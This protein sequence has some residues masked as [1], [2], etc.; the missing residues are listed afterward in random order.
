MLFQ[1]NI[2]RLTL[3]MMKIVQVECFD[4]TCWYFWGGLVCGTYSEDL[5]GFLDDG[6]GQIWWICFGAMAMA[7]R[8]GYVLYVW[9]CFST[10]GVGM[11]FRGVLCW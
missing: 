2:T 10:A 11:R 4:A 6:R 9:L 3:Y 1:E 5:A 7:V 8:F